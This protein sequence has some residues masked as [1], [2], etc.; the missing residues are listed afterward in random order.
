MLKK[1]ILVILDGL[2]DRPVKEFGGLTPLEAAKTPNMDRFAKDSEC[3]VMYTLGRGFVPGSDTAHLA[4]LGYDPEE[5]YSGRGPLEAAGVRLKLEPGDIA[6]RANF[7][8]VDKNKKITDRRAGRIKDV[9]PLTEALDG[10]EIPVEKENNGEGVKE[11]VKFI[12]KPGTSYRAVLVMQ[13]KGLSSTITDV[14]PHESGRK[15][16]LCA[17][18]DG[19]PEAAKTADVLNKF[20]K[21]SH[22]ILNNHDYNK[23][24]EKPANFLLVRGAGKYSSVKPFEETFRMKACCIAGGGLYKGVAGHLGM[25]I[26]DVDEPTEPPE[27]TGRSDTNIRKKFKRAVAET[28]I[29]DFIFTH[30]KATDIYGHDGD[31]EGKKEFI[32][33]IDDAFSEFNK[34]DEETLLIVTADHSTPC[35]LK[36]HS[37]DS[38]P[39]M[40]YGPGVRV[41]KVDAFNER[42][43]TGGGLG[44]M[45]GKDIMRHIMNLSGKLPLYGA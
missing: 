35:E 17:P 3:G 31:Y 2:G 41:D 24:R 8:T 14:D 19:S 9:A 26:I 36:D 34:L 20:M 42:A 43:C 33:K 44:T 16:K 30:V 22:E 37:A 12:V 11:V 5:Y 4:L 15:V 40:F 13:G 29:F 39:I 45:A 28:K 18:L 6:F 32:E 7:G 27:V 21:E 25:E 23:S 38:V 1:V 10:I